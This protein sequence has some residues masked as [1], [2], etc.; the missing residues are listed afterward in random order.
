MQ[1]TQQTEANVLD[2][3]ISIFEGKFI[4]RIYDKR[5]H[6]KFPVVRLIPRFANRPDNLG[7]STFYSQVIRCSRVCNSFEGFKFRILFL[8][9][10]FVECKFDSNKL[11]RVYK[12]C[13]SRNF[14]SEKFSD[15][16][17]ILN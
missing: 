6:F 8:F 15:S 14:I 1:N 16:L 9:A 11:S 10:L 17:R 12:K 4:T 13:I 3:D 5:D 2:L 7:Y